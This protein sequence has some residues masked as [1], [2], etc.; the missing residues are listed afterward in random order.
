MLNRL[1]SGF[2]VI[3]TSFLL[4]GL[5][6]CFDTLE[7]EKKGGNS[8]LQP[9]FEERFEQEI[10]TLQSL[11][12][13]GQSLAGLWMVFYSKSGQNVNDERFS[14]QA[15]SL[16]QISHENESTSLQVKNLKNCQTDTPSS[17]HYTI[18]TT[19]INGSSF[20]IPIDGSFLYPTA[21]AEVLVQVDSSGRILDFAD[22]TNSE[23]DS[24]T[25]SM[26][27]YKVQDETAALLGTLILDSVEYPISCLSYSD[28]GLLLEAIGEDTLQSEQ[29]IT[30]SGAD[31]LFF[32]VIEGSVQS[33]QVPESDTSEFISVD[34]QAI[35][36]AEEFK[37]P[38]DGGI[39]STMTFNVNSDLTIDAEFT[40]P[41][42]FSGSIEV[43]LSNLSQ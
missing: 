12:L 16:L 42:G 4:A 40:R 34:I 10:E 43:N 24:S 30:G 6:A 22:Y 39:V 28:T 7:K 32:S 20:H 19:V 38:N 13:N 5:T 26:A 37:T 25:I 33:E 11:P 3:C 17:Y 23:G 41:D 18:N 27:A 21:S 35:G 36:V 9:S 1:M 31:E 29:V 14:E 2:R 15:W 8:T